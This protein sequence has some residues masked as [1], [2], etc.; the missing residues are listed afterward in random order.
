VE[1]KL[2]KMP[3]QGPR[4][5]EPSPRD[6]LCQYFTLGYARVEDVLRDRE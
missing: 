4:L 2:D 6:G 5:A 3:L 1:E